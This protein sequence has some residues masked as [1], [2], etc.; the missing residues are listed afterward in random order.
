MK[1]SFLFLTASILALGMASQASA[2]DLIVAPVYS[3]APPMISAIYDWSGL[4]VGLNAGGGWS[5][6]GSEVGDLK[7]NGA[8]VGGQIGYRWQASNWVF[9]IEGQGN[10]ADFT[11]TTVTDRADIGPGYVQYDRPRVDSFA[12]I[13]GQ[14]GYAVNNVL[15]YVK[16]GG[17]VVS[18]KHRTLTEKNGDF[19]GDVSGSDSQWGGVVGVGLDLGLAPN[20]SVG[21]EW[22]HV[23]LSAR[24][25]NLNGS[26]VAE[27]VFGTV[28][29][30]GRQ[31]I[32]MALVR[33]NYR[34]GGPVV[35]RY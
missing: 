7:A 19:S 32:D 20:W 10:W 26:T 30:M 22:D 21:I 23:F 3:K 27:P 12:L 13:T 18:N 35:A 16:G 1:K 4:Y 24:D 34:F 28:G 31:D 2:A 15:L 25:L 9:G 8:T 11:R 6:V 29:H 33:L 17:A 5:R 14:L